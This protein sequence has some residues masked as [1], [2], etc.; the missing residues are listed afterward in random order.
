MRLISVSFLFL[1]LSISF[2]TIAQDSVS[3]V[4]DAE[5]SLQKTEPAAAQPEQSTKATNKEE[6]KTDTKTDTT[7]QIESE[8][9]GKS[10][11]EQTKPAEKEPAPQDSDS[12]RTMELPAQE[13]QADT[14]PVDKEPS[15]EQGESEKADSSENVLVK[16]AEDLDVVVEEDEDLILV[17]DDEEELIIADEKKESVPPTGATDTT[18][19]DT[20]SAEVESFAEDTQSQQKPVVRPATE[21]R[22]KETIT[23]KPIVIGEKDTTD[24][25]AP[26]KKE[27]PVAI[28][29]MR[30]IDFA[31]NL[32]DYR[33]PKKAMFMSLLLP[34]LGQAYTKKYWKTAI[35]GVAEAAIVGFSIKYALDGRDKKEEARDFADLHFSPAKF[36]GFYEDFIQ[37]TEHDSMGVDDYTMIFGEDL[38]EQKRKYSGI[39]DPG[40]SHDNKYRQDFD[41]IIEEEAFV[42]GWDD[43]ELHFDYESGFTLDSVAYVYAYT[44]YTSDTLWLVNMTTKDHSDTLQSAVF[45]YSENQRKYSRMMTR[46]NH[47]YSISG[48]LIFLLIANHII[49][50]VDA[51]ISARAYNDK[52]LNKKSVWQHINLDQRISLNERGMESRYGIVVRF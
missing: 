52:L 29:E 7:K 47:L 44:Y 5:E 3:V 24:T 2:L 9:A 45:G 10:P 28:E 4:P 33:S 25:A 30:S 21:T 23:P 27:K 22:E 11:A 34:G 48:N 42:Q 36:F 6:I 8:E 16:E 15:P 32:N 1:V 39:T 18:Q 19:K 20:L 41:A 46:S 50:A 51:F 35:F 31:K 14:I 40:T 38:D 49:S 13:K 26:E 37:Y 43:C 17:D 12:A